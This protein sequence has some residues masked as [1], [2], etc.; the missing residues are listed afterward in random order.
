MLATKTD[1]CA[2]F[3]AA[4]DVG[5]YRVSEAGWYAIDDNDKAVLGPF[6]SLDECERAIQDR[7]NP[8]V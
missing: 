7:K 3:L 2:T 1:L 5:D 6:T 8:P 4:D